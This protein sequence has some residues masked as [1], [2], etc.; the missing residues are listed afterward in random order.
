M[1]ATLGSPIFLYT[2]KTTD[3]TPVE[4]HNN[5]YYKRDDYYAPYGK[6]N[7]NGGKTRQAICLFRE[8]KD[9][10]KNKY[11]GGVVTGSSVNSPQAPIIAAVAKDFGFKCVIGVGGTTPKTIDTHHMMRLSRHYGA[12]IENVA[13]H[14]YTVAIDLSLI[15]I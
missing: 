15:H 11:N 14:G 13:G 10:I 1:Q 9:E 2:M 12:D 4:I 7:V 3:L 5:I 6:D 8:L